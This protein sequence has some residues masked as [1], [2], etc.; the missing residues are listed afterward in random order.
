MAGPLWTGPCCEALPAH[1]RGGGDTWA[2]TLGAVIAG[3]QGEGVRGRDQHAQ[4]SWGCDY[5][6]DNGGK[7]GT[8]EA[9]EAGWVTLDRLV[10]RKPAKAGSQPGSH[11]SVMAAESREPV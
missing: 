8:E 7:D 5:S 10:G 3:S 2:G 4:G 11:S 1:S 6:L 9:G